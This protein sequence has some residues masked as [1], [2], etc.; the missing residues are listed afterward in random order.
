MEP[1][2]YRRPREVALV[3]GDGEGIGHDPLV[4]HAD[5]RTP[6]RG[7]VARSDGHPRI[8]LAA[9]CLILASARTNGYELGN[10]TVEKPTT[11]ATR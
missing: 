8:V 4:V 2:P 11:P 10:R 6:R 9:G 7:P 3:A 5:G 1:T